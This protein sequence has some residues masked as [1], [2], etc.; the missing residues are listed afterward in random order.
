MQYL[1]QNITNVLQPN[2]SVT[3]NC[4]IDDSNE[5]VAKLASV[6]PAAIRVEPFSFARESHS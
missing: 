2:V 4:F 6:I 5:S 1:G 3:L